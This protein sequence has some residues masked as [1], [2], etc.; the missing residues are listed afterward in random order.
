MYAP[1]PVIETEVFATVPARFRRPGFRSEWTEVMR[2][3][4][5]T[6]CFLEGPSFDRDGNLYVCDIPFGRIFRFAPDGTF[7]LAAEYDGE[8]CG[9]KFRKDGR[10]LI[11]DFV[12]GVMELDPATGTVRPFLERYLLQRFR[13][14]NDLVFADNGDLYFTD[15]G[16]SGMHDPTGQ[17]FRL[18]T[19]GR[20]ELVLGNVPSPNGL[21]LNPEQNALYLAVTRGNCVWRVPLM[22]DGQIAKV[23]IFI[24][25]SGSLAGPDGLAIDEAGN[26]AIA[27]A[28]LGVV[29]LFSRLGE[30]LF[31]IQSRTGLVQ[32]NLAYGWPDR[33]WLYVT[34][35]DTGNILRARLPTPG[36][37]MYSHQP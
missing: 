27:H 36:R 18:R 31:R 29:W 34:E 5:P 24:Q 3:G 9:L 35:S 7:S 33:H 21:V 22:K 15:Q 23:G 25:L 19:D 14:V 12:H 20:I 28:G 1:P 26:L 16:Q 4:A 13:G 37:T 10:A 8:P 17:L 6:D 2:H 30:P 32:T 11:T